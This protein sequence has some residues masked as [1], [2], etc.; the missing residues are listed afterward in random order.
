MIRRYR[1]SDLDEVLDARARAS[2][3]AHPFLALDFPERERLAIRELHLPRAETRV[4]E[5]GGLF[6]RTAKEA[7]YVSV[8]ES[9]NPPAVRDRGEVYIEIGLAVTR[10]AEH[11][12]L[13][14]GLWDGGA[15][16]TEG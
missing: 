5:S 10:P 13:R 3:L 6:G 11:I 8:D 12:V 9:I 2:A 4:W 7:Y 15:K 1:L 16:V 14:L